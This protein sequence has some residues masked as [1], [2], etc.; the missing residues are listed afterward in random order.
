MKSNLIVIAILLPLILTSCAGKN[1]FPLTDL[2][3]H[4]KGK[5]TI[6]DLAKKSK[7]EN[8]QY[9]IAVNCGLGFPVLR[10]TLSLRFLKVI[11][12]FMLPCRRKEGNG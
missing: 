8:I 1:D 11:P 12:S 10:L 3:V 7:K 9:G 4:I 2:H 5:L 6:E